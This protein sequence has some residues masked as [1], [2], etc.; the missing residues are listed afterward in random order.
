[1]Q[2]RPTTLQK[3]RDTHSTMDEHGLVRCDGVAVAISGIAL[4]QAG[5]VF[6]A[7]D[8]KI[9]LT[10]DGVNLLNRKTST[11]TLLQVLRALAQHEKLLLVCNKTY[12]VKFRRMTIEQM[13]VEGFVQIN[14]SVVTLTEMGRM[15]IGIG[16]Q[17]ITFDVPIEKVDAVRRA[18]REVLDAAT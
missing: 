17:Q 12:P 9:T 14:G 3:I 18:V 5:V 1:M 10:A 4:L 11:A 13:E 6:R 15:R 16:T 2:I 8:G 7:D